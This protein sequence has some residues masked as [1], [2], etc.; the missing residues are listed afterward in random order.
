[1][2]ID[3]LTTRHAFHF[4]Y[5]CTDV[6]RSC[7]LCQFERHGGGL[8]LWCHISQQLLPPVSVCLAMLQ[9]D[10]AAVRAARGRVLLQCEALD[11]AQSCAALYRVKAT[12]VRISPPTP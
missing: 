8:R 9:V 3:Q 7:W 12:S 4:S 10:L 1:M 11:L 5:R 6:C 2:R